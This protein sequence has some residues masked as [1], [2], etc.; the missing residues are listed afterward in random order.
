[1]GDLIP[2]FG[3]LTGVM[4]IGAGIWGVVRLT[5]GPI[6]QA[7]ARRIHGH[8]MADP[9]LAADM[10]QLREQVETLQRQLAE[11][12]ERLDFTE[13][14]LTRGAAESPERGPG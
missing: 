13:R 5:Q 14:L 9:E 4:I 7:L 11:T 6:G 1:M 12:E 3:M 8:S 2:I 10:Q